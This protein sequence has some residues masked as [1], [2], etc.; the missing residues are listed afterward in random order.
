MLLYANISLTSVWFHLCTVVRW[1][2][3]KQSNDVDIKRDFACPTILD[4][5]RCTAEE[6]K[7][8]HAR[9][10]HRSLALIRKINFNS[11]NEQ[12]GT[13]AVC[14]KFEPAPASA[15]VILQQFIQQPRKGKAPRGKVTKGR[16]LLCWKWRSF[17]S[18]VVKLWKALFVVGLNKCKT[19]R[20][21]Q[22]NYVIHKRKD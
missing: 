1:I 9:R 2:E 21:F 18:F 22:A 5:R 6:V 19:E 16:E 12:K 20:K 8:A 17:L 10:Y 15:S 11:E 13:R 14:Y 3:R 7:Y 4:Q